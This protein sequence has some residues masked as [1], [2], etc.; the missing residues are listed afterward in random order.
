MPLPNPTVGGTAGP[1][2]SQVGVTDSNRDEKPFST[3]FRPPELVE[4]AVSSPEIKGTG[5]NVTRRS[6][7]GDRFSGSLCRTLNA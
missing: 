5:I 1:I 3:V 7:A 6:D 2:V 4:G